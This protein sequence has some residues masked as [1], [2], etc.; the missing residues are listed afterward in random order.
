MNNKTKG[1]PVYATKSLQ[2][3]LNYYCNLFQSAVA[4]I[5]A[6]A[7]NSLVYENEGKQS[8]NLITSN[9]SVLYSGAIFIA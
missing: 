8:G 9:N 7:I 3:R 1:L 4:K 2:R 5:N 6:N